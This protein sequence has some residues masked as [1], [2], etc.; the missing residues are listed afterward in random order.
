M[1]ILT[2]IKNKI[3]AWLRNL[4]SDEVNKLDS[5]LRREKNEL[6]AHLTLFAVQIADFSKGVEHFN[7]AIKHQI[8]VSDAAQD[9]IKL[10]ATIKELS[11]HTADVINLS[12]RIYPVR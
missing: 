4:I 10:R 6:H 9:N 1:S 3:E 5:S 11:G 2:K 8:E 7:E 12:K